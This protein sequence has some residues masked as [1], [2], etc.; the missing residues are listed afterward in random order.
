MVT[1]PTRILGV[2]DADGGLSGEL[3]YVIGHLLGTAECALCDI[4]HS[5]LGRRRSWDRMVA[6]LDIPFDL[7]HRNELTGAETRALQALELPVVV[8]LEG[9]VPRNGADVPSGSLTA[10]V[11]LDRTALQGC[12]GD[13][14]AFHAALSRTLG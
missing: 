8:G 10:R 1:R 5:P 4:T 7:R 2:Y 12:A 9:P 6:A 3:R 13:V 11:L 14:G